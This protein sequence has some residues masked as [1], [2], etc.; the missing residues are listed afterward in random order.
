MLSYVYHF[1]SALVFS[2][3]VE[4]FTVLAL[5]VA[6]KQNKKTAYL[7]AVGTLLTIPYVWFVFPVV[8]WSE[9]TVALPLAELFAFVIEV[10]VYR[11]FGKVHWK[12]AITFSF[13][14]NLMSY[15]LWQ[16]I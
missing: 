8:F 1:L 7:G 15:M 2:C 5:C 11:F 14:A 13:L 10:F 12:I 16:L 6:L 4:S 3:A 9:R